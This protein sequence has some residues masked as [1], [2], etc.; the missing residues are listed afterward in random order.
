M[1]GGRT[2]YGTGTMVIEQPAPQNPYI[3]R[4]PGTLMAHLTASADALSHLRFHTYQVLTDASVADD[5]ARLAQLAVSELVG[6]AVR[7]CG[8][9]VS[10]IV[11]VHADAEEVTVGVTDPEPTL[12]PHTGSH[13]LDSAE[14]ESGR[15]LDIL[16]LLCKSVDVEATGSGKQVRCLIALA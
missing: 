14:A 11:D 3:R 9:G 15:G 10:L 6:N 7:A 13:V 2:T 4:G 16:R 8:D 5:I 12:L 1:T